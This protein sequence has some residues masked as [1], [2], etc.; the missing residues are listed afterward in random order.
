MNNDV[1]SIRNEPLEIGWAIKLGILD[2]YAHP[3][4]HAQFLFIN[5]RLKR[6]WEMRTE[7]LAGGKFFSARPIKEVRY[8]DV[9][10]N[11]KCN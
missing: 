10:S 4:P 8:E 5:N 9:I 1:L 2:G 3:K 7:H 11:Y 6:A